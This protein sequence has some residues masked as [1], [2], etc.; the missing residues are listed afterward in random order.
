MAVSIKI[1]PK[2]SS[3]LLLKLLLIVS[4]LISLIRP[5]LLE[6]QVENGL[7]DFA[8]ELHTTVTIQTDSQARIKHAFKITNQT[9][10]T[11]ISQYGLKISSSQLANISVISSGQVI[12]PETV[13][14]P[15]KN[16][17]GPGE[18]SIGLTFPDKVVGEGKTRQF[19]ISY[20]HPDAAVINGSILEVTLPPHARPQDYQKYTVDLITPT[21]FG[22]PVRTTPT[23]HTFT[24][25]GQNVITSFNQGADT[26]IFALFGQE[27][28]FN[29]DLD[30]HLTNTSNNPGITQVALPPDTT[31][32]RLFYQQLE[33]QPEKIENDLD[34]NWIAT[35]QVP[36]GQSIIVNL[37][38]VAKLSLE[39]FTEVPTTTPTEEL[40]VA[41]EFW[42]VN[43]SQIQQL[44]QEQSTAEDINQYVVDTLSYNTQRA[45]NQPERLGTLTSLAQPDQ[46]VC[47]EYTDAFITIARAA[48]IPAR[49][50][51]GYAQTQNSELRP[52]SLVEDILHAWPEYYNSETGRWTP[53]DPTWQDTTGGVDYFHQLDLNHLVFAINGRQSSTPHPAGSYKSLDEPEKTVK[54]SFADSFPLDTDPS[55]LEDVLKIELIPRQ[56]AGL[57]LPGLY[58]LK[59][60]NQS[61]GAFYQL[62]FTV[63]ADQSRLV[64]TDLPT[65]LIALLPFQ[66]QEFPLWL[67]SGSSW[68]SQNDTIEISLNHV[69]TKLD[70]TSGPKI[71]AILQEPRLLLAVG[72]GLIFLTLITGSLLVF[73]RKR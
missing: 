23:N 17:T 65:E 73:R 59:I 48:E 33:P 22:G 68:W 61:G 32:Q 15:A 46:A 70:I 28:L 66:T 58:T 67:E 26:G 13:T 45:L 69:K 51:T 10:T 36:A 71:S 2:K 21:Q 49:R 19:S 14:I 52:L 41:R 24:V 42:P 38:A 12:E 7:Q 3:R 30:Y 6:A 40:L 16:K 9:P 57:K 29:L 37:Q 4:S 64:Q 27:Q 62:P 60:T 34:G 25:T 56:V 39:P 54:V 35:Y 11:Y 53:I 18:T 1:C 31:Y 72:G 43:H 47:Q 50:V 5:N 20:T 55:S 63:Q 44:A 8:V